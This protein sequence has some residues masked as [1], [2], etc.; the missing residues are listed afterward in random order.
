MTQLITRL[1]TF[2][3]VAIFAVAFTVTVLAEGAASADV[4]KGKRIY[5]AVGLSLPKTRSAG[6]AAVPESEHDPL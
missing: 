3:A 1:G 4:A 6:V 2:A 5:L